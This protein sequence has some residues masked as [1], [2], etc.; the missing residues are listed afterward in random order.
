MTFL[1]WALDDIRCLDQMVWQHLAPRLFPDLQAALDEVT[2][3]NNNDTNTL[4]DKVHDIF[5]QFARP[6]LA[7]PPFDSR[8]WLPWLKKKLGELREY[9]REVRNLEQG[10]NRNSG[11]YASSA[12][13]PPETKHHSTPLRST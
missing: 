8:Q 5:D 4:A 1:T 12:L 11:M 3:S 10:I 7:L 6:R 9:D 2:E 13:D